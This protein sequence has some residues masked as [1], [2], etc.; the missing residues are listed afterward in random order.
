MCRTANGGNRA[1]SHRL[2][3]MVKAACFCGCVYSF[4]GDAGDCPWCGE[5]ASVRDT[6]PTSTTVQVT[7]LARPDPDLPADV[8]G[9]EAPQPVTHS[10]PPA[11]E[12]DAELRTVMALMG[13][14]SAVTAVASNPT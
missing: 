13:W 14:S 12:V 3:A 2:A 11:A 8:A 9:S 5:R 7:R 1:G 10:L 6:G 4:D